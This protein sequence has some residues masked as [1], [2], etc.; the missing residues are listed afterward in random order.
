MLKRRKS[1][2]IIRIRKE[3]SNFGAEKCANMKFLLYFFFFL[4]SFITMLS[5]EKK[6]ADVKV[7]LVLSG[8]GAKGLAHIGVLKVIDSIGVR[9]DYI[10]GSSMGA[11]V[12]GLYASGYTG[13]QLDSLFHA[14]D[15]GSI[16]QD[17]L[18]RSS[19]TFYEK[20]D[21]EKYAL[22]L[23]V[24]DGKIRLPKGI[25]NGQNFYNFYSKVT[26]HVRGIKDFSK[27][28]IPFFCTA[29]DIETGKGLVFDSGNL[30][31]AVVASGALP[32]VYSPVMYKGK[33]ITDGG[34]TD[35]YPVEEMK[36]R[37]VE[38][39]IGVDVQDS[40]MG[41][42]ELNS[43]TNIMLQV[44]NFKTIEAMKIKRE[45][46]DIYIRPDIK[47]FSVIGFDHGEE[48]IQEGAQ[49]TLI[50]LDKLKNIVAQQKRT[51][52]S[53]H[54]IK[55][56]QKLQI[57]EVVINKSDNYSRAYVK[58]KMG[59][60]TPSEISL[61]KLNQGLDNLYA[62]K[63]FQNIRYNIITDSLQKNRLELKVNEVET[64]NYFRFG[65]HYDNLYQTAAIVNY[66][67]KKLFFKNDVLSFDAILGDAPRYTFDYYI[68]KGNYWSIGLRNYYYN[69]D[70]VFDY[71]TARAR[72]DLPDIP[73]N[74]IDLEYRDL[75]TELYV[76]TLLSETF[77]FR[78]GVA[79]KWL[80][81]E[82]ETISADVNNLSGTV[83][84]N[85][86]FYGF[87]SDI[88]FDSLNDKYFPSKG[89]FFEASFKGYPFSSQAE[90]EF[91]EF[92]I[93]KTNFI[94][95]RSL[96]TKFSLV[97]EL[98]GGFR[99]GRSEGINSLD[100]FLGGYGAKT[101]NNQISFLGRDFYEIS[102][103][104]FVKV[105][106]SLDYKIFEK[107][108]L[109]ATANY[110]NIGTRIFNIEDWFRTAGLSGYALGYG[111]ESIIGPMQVKYAFSPDDDTQNRVFISVGYWF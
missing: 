52:K 65:L 53:V 7:G 34:V 13:K 78:L 105:A 60:K 82:T 83:F 32:S 76:E 100:F 37:G 28:P 70:I 31:E 43:V 64:K 80:A 79:Q 36:N 25:S 98:A 106:F 97:S 89:L 62:T 56:I 73:I 110:A 20:E 1:L 4:S 42:K 44:S 2:I 108:H 81:I 30:P 95:T 8:G 86:N 88:K 54:R 47:R 94:Y 10:A 96:G 51:S 48:I 5:Q 38:L 75:S 50:Q 91:D 77:A 87:F 63:N 103:D 109:N 45:L 111:Y 84:D 107:H 29:T 66:T 14:V 85:V 61:K 19:K 11:I 22:T 3:N 99:L 72:R 55:P 21:A 67:R 92:A 16:I 23:P 93:A 49:K 9:L 101:I 27:L 74:N 35:N 41:R 6:P 33:L 24:V 90:S 39:V 71:E 15:F 59:I 69:F 102:G 46:T 40:L 68:D 18:P 17:K 58:G 57:D 104:S 12:G 26:T